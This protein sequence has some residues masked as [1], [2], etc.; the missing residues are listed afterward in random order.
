MAI[1]TGV[2]TLAQYANQANDPLITAIVNSLYTFGSV[3]RDVPIASKA[4]LK[5][6]GSR[7]QGSLPTINWR[8]I[9]EASVTTSATATPF[10]ENVY[11]VDNNIDVDVALLRDQNSVGDPRRVQLM[12]YLESLTYDMN[13]KFFNN[14]PVTGDLDAPIGIRYRLD[15]VSAFGLPSAC[16]INGN[17]V[18]MTNSLTASSTGQ[19]I[20]LLDQTLQEIGSPDGNGC[21]IYMNRL[22]SRRLDRGIKL[23]G[24]GGGFDMTQDAFDRRVLTY[25]NARMYTVGVKADQSTEIITNTETAAGADGSSTFTSFYVVN[26]GEDRFI[27]WQMAPLQASYIGQIPSEPTIDRTHISWSLGYV[28]NHNRA[29]ARVYNVAVS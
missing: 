9:N 29:V 13:D 25:R 12:A 5:V 19:F 26:Y 8:K 6:N 15:N 14:G 2:L 23:M 17:G 1:P 16:K 7:I 18:V 3:F 4:T 22:L 20:E 24:S 21:V 28:Q 10:S 27:P 11:L